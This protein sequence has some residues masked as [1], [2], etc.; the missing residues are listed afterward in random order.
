MPIVSFSFFMLIFSHVLVKFSNQCRVVSS[1]TSA[2]FLLLMSGMEKRCVQL[3]D[4]SQEELTQ[5]YHCCNAQ[6]LDCLYHGSIVIIKS[7]Y[8]CSVNFP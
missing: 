3:A 2:T 6:Q 7:I 5:A 8:Y 1:R 4:M